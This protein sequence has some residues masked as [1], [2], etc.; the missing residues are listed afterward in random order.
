MNKIVPLITSKAFVALDQQQIKSAFP[1]D[2]KST[3]YVIMI[4]YVQKSYKDTNY[5]LFLPTMEKLLMYVLNLQAINGVFNILPN[6]A[7]HLEWYFSTC[8]QH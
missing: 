6:I 8:S 3:K 1:F 7:R 2:I 4:W 5:I